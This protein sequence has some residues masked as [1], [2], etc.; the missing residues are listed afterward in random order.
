[1]Q[2]TLNKSILT[3][4]SFGERAQWKASQSR[5]EFISIATFETWRS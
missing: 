1:M 3:S 2:E 5:H 4:A